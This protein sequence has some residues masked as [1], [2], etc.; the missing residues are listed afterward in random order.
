MVPTGVVLWNNPNH[1]SPMEGTVLTLSESIDNFN[2]YEVLY[3]PSASVNNVLLTTGLLPVGLGTSMIMNGSEGYCRRAVRIDKNQ[4][5]IGV[6]VA[7]ATSTNNIVCIPYQIC[8][9]YRKS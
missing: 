3:K 7:G 4:A 9:Y 2:K 5:N 1:T 6:G 8:G